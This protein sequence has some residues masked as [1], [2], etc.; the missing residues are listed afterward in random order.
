MDRLSGKI[1]SVV[2]AGQTPG[3]T[4]GNGRA[5][6]LRFAQEGATVLVVDRDGDSADETLEM[7][8]SQGGEGSVLVADVTDE[9]QCAAV[10]ATCVERYGRLDIL[11]NNVGIGAGDRG[12]TTMTTAIWDRIFDTNLKSVMLT[13]KHALPVMRAQGAG[14]ITNISSIAAV[15]SMGLVSYKTSKAALNAYTHALATGNARYGIRANVIMP[16]LMDTPMAIEGY[17]A[18]GHD[19]A[20]LIAERNAA[21]PLGGHMGTAWDVANAA[22]FLASDEARFI[23]G[24]CLPVDGGQSALIG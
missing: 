21:V 9:A 4:I 20:A 23:T 11:H 14:V 17:V 10:T 12:A 24:V 19:R 7:I 13:C 22:L 5:T 15:C 1:A 3:A 8:V 16:G 18:A 6:A 2:G